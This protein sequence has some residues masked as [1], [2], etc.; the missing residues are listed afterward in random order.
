MDIYT[1]DFDVSER[2][3]EVYSAEVKKET[4]SSYWI[5]KSPQFGMRT[6]VPKEEFAT[7]RQGAVEIF[8]EKANKDLLSAARAVNAAAEAV[9]WATTEQLVQATYGSKT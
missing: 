3:Y 8:Q 1:V 7:T 5:D 6:H 9:T 2:T 4:G